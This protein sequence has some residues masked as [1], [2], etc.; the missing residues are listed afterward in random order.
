MIIKGMYN[1]REK[2]LLGKIMK[3]LHY[4]RITSYFENLLYF[5]QLSEKLK[6][7]CINGN[8]IQLQIILYNINV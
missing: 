7:Q 3:I 1:Y 5:A 2:I 6:C 4:R 8:R